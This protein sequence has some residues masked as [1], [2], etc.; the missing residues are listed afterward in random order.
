MTDTEIEALR[1]EMAAQLADEQ[2]IRQQIRTEILLM[3]EAELEAE[4]QAIRARKT[5]Q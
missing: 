5:K 1:A 4:Y 2:R 3:S